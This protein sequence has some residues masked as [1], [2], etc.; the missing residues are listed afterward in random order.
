MIGAAHL[1]QRTAHGQSASMQHMH[2]H[3]R[4]LRIFVAQQFLHRPNII[5][6]LEQLRR[7]AVSKGMTADA[8]GEPCHTTGPTDGPLQPTL[9]GV[10]AA[11][12]PRL[13]VFRQPVRRKD[14]LPDPEPAS[15][16]IL[17]FQRKRSVDRGDPLSDILR[18]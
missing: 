13:W 18:M 17:A 14:V 8:F 15:M 5:A 11:D 7:K 2:I 1:I 16:W 12:D 6:L 9:M 4:R 10:M 3:H